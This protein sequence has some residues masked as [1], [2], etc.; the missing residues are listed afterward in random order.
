MGYGELA[1]K[2]K[3]GYNSLKREPVFKYFNITWNQKLG[4]AEILV[5]NDAEFKAIIIGNTKKSN[6]RG[7]MY[8]FYTNDRKVPFPSV[9]EIIRRLEIVANRG[10]LA[11][12]DAEYF[13]WREY[14]SLEMQ[15]I[16]FSEIIKREVKTDS[17][18]KTNHKDEDL[19]FTDSMIKRMD[20]MDQAVYQMCLT[21]LGLE[22]DEDYA[23][24][25]PWNIG[26][27]EEIKESAIRILNK[28]QYKVCYPFI[29]E[30]EGNSD[31]CGLDS[32]GFSECF[33]HP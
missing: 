29:K 20:E 11:D 24:R 16:Y 19:E 28:N 1:R 6:S 15:R 27:V 14:G 30:E 25:F 22:N 8:L 3:D 4:T 21:L 9:K 2:I 10:I 17:M 33:R 32:C 18:K 13:D 31:F 5:E 26:I 12:K 23:K 7:Y